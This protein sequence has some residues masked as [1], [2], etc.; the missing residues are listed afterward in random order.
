MQYHIG[1]NNQQLGQFTEAQIREGLERGTFLASD[2]TWREG[3][4]E[5]KPLDQVFGFAAARSLSSPMVAAVP[6]AA[7][8]P[9]F[10]PA[11]S[12]GIGVMP[13]PGTAVASLVLG[14]IALVSL[15][16]CL[17]GGVL[18]IPGA[19]CGHM[20]L[21][22][23]KRSGGMAQGRGLAIGGLACSYATIAIGVLMLLVFGVMMIAAAG[24]AK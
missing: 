20:A 5:W 13:V 18:A 2:L 9:P 12:G 14:I 7:P 8:M 11:A 4:T 6:A 15:F 21:S 16:A 24:S 17:V 22:E 19:I 1:R 10:M 23:I 3:M